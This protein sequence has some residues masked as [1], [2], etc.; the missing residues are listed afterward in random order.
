MYQKQNN[1]KYWLDVRHN[2]YIVGTCICPCKSFPL[3]GLLVMWEPLLWIEDQSLS[4]SETWKGLWG[5]PF[6][7]QQII[8]QVDRSQGGARTTRVANSPLPHQPASTRYA[9]VHLEILHIQ[10]LICCLPQISKR[11]IWLKLMESKMF[12]ACVWRSNTLLGFPSEYN[13]MK[14][15]CVKNVCKVWFYLIWLLS[16][17]NTC[18][19]LN[20]WMQRGTSPRRL[21]SNRSSPSERYVPTKETRSI[22]SSLKALWDRRR[23]CRVD[24]M[25]RK[26]KAA[27]W[28]MW[29]CWRLSLFKQRG[30]CIGTEVNLL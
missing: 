22:P 10:L 20:C 8:F 7:V 17:L 19:F 28:L 27:M 12:P 23:D 13:G 3:C 16:S 25:W 14:W 6:H 18:R 21:L 29:L 1:R 5:N 15:N 4:I 26:V 2:A 9:H 30:K 11:L 24:R